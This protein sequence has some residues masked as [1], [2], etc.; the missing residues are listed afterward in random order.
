MA[1]AN[2]LDQ[3]DDAKNL[4]AGQSVLATADTDPDI[5]ARAQRAAATLGLPQ[6]ALTSVKD[7]ETRVQVQQANA[8][9]PTAPKTAGWLVDRSNA[10]VT[11]PHEVSGLARLEQLAGAALI[12]FNPLVGGLSALDAF[13]QSYNQGAQPGDLARAAVSHAAS[14]AGSIARGFGSAMDAITRLQ[15]GPEERAFEA[16]IGDHGPMPSD[17]T[18]VVAKP[19]IA[20]GQA[21]APQVQTPI[22]NAVGAAAGFVPLVGAALLNPA[23]GVVAGASQGADQI[24]QDAQAKG[25]D[26]SE[27]ADIATLA[28]AGLQGALTLVGIKAPGMGVILPK[29]AGPA[30]STLVKL[31]LAGAENSAARV[32]TE[33]ATDRVLRLGV[34]TAENAATGGLM[35]GGSN[36]IEKSSIDPQKDLGEGVGD[37]AAQMALFGG[38]FH[39]AHMLPG[40]LKEF[41]DTVTARMAANA[42]ATM[43]AAMREA[44]VSPLAG[45]APGRFADLNGLRPEVYGVSPGTAAARH[46]AI[47]RTP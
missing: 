17:S 28:D 15:E 26:G 2:V 32:A 40:A 42:N 30:M 39:S 45:R 6:S 34:A 47:C 44:E 7:A 25:Q 16:E 41:S 8:A 12:P 11:A 24:A 31:G 35:Q 21:T 29:I 37:S 1:D 14:A 3:L 18:A 20:A 43:I 38:L 19:L 27:K 22:T 33:V 9:L 36:L 10:A 13:N 23:L 5:A 4:A 46:A